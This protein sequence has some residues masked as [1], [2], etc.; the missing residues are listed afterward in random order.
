MTDMYSNKL[1]DN[2]MLAMSKLFIAPDDATY[3]IIRVPH[4][5][6]ISNVWL[7]VTTAYA[8]GVPSI[9]IG[10]KGNKETA[11]LAGFMSNSIAK[12]KELGL[13]IAQK[14]ALTAFP[15]KYFNAGSGAVTV[16]VSAGGATTEGNFRV[17]CEYAV[18]Q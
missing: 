6:F 11:V 3:D 13:K 7:E 1:A 12:P 17:F 16:T 9:T 18:I 10:W 15:G 2:R 8:A 5:S 4:W 14:D